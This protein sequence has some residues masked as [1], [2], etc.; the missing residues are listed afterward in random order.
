MNFIGI[1]LHRKTISICV[2]D[3]ERTVVDHKRFCCC[4]PKRIVWLFEFLG[5]FQVVVEAVA[6]KRLKW[7][8]RCRRR[9]ETC[10]DFPSG[11][12]ALVA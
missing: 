4:E 7:A 2:V 9:W 1:D 12:L 3:K 8:D 10:K 5:P 11:F 6:D